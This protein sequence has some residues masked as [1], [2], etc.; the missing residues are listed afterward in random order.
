[1]K[2]LSI[3]GIMLLSASGH[4]DPLSC[5]KA[6]E[7][8]KELNTVNKD[9][10]RREQIF[11][12]LCNKAEDS[13][14]IKCFKAGI[15]EEKLPWKGLGSWEHTRYVAHLCSGA[16]S[17][18][19]VKCAVS[20]WKDKAVTSMDVVGGEDWWKFIGLRMLCSGA[21]STAPINCLKKASKDKKI[22]NL[23]DP[24]DE[25]TRVSHIIQL[26]GSDSD[27]FEIPEKSYREMM[28]SN[29]Q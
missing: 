23:L 28:R 15:K 20:A 16:A 19:P 3:I 26:C 10:E 29:H 24:P 22:L 17:M 1:M 6:A 12:K 2:I 13:A 7:S 14:P 21:K 18:A 4:S 11:F 9:Y 25:R 8:D 27:L 5:L